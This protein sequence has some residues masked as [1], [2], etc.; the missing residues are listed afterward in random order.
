MQRNATSHL[1]RERARE[2]QQRVRTIKAA[3]D[4]QLSAAQFEELCRSFEN[5]ARA[6]VANL[7]Q[8]RDH[9]LAFLDY[10]PE[11]RRSLSTTNAVEAINGQL[12]RLRQNNGGYFH[13][14]EILQMKL[15]MLVL[16]LEN[17]RWRRVPA[18]WNSVLPQLNARFEARF[19]EED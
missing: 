11:I 19:E 7:R 18:T 9:Y 10:P 6:F 4:A 14:Q 16:H 15:G 2:F 8:K 13:S 5:D 1:D 12:E 3:W 17:H